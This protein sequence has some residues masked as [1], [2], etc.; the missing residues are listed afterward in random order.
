VRV[1]VSPMADSAAGAPPSGWTLRDV[2]RVVKKEVTSMRWEQGMLVF[3][4]IYFLLVFTTFAIEDRQIARMICG[5]DQWITPDCKDGILTTLDTMFVSLDMVFLC[6]FALEIGIKFFGIGVL[7]YLR[8]QTCTDGVINTFDFIVILI[9]I[10]MNVFVLTTDIFDDAGSASLLPLLKFVRLLRAVMLMTRLQRSRQRLLRMRMVGLAAPVEKVFEIITDLRE[11]VAHA[12]DDKALAWT[13]DLI[14]KEELY[15]VSFTDSKSSSGMHLT[16]EMTDW[17]RSNL[18]ASLPGGL[19]TKPNAATDGKRGSVMGK[20]TPNDPNKART[21]TTSMANAVVPA[22]I[23]K[24]IAEPNVGAILDKLDQWDFDVFAL[25][26]ATNGNPLAVGGM[27]LMTK[28]GVLDRVPIPKDTLATYLQEIEKGY[29]RANPFH[30]ATHAS[31]VMFTTHYF[32][33]AP[34]LRDMTG[35]LDKFAAVLA[36]AVHDYAHPGLSNPFLIV[37]REDKA[38]MYNDQSVLE[39]FHVAGSFRVMLTT[40]GCDITEGMTRE[41]FRQFRETMV[42]MIL[43]TDLKTHFEHLGRLKTRVAT[44]AYS[45]VER[46]DVLLLLGQ[47]LHAADISN[48]TKGRPL[49]MRWTERVMKEFWQQGEKEK[50]LGLPISAFMDRSN[51]QVPQCQLGFVNVLVKPL[52][53]EWH[54]LLGET[55]Q[56]AIN[57][58]E[59][60]LKIWET[61]G[62]APCENWHKEDFVR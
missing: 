27:H 5:G 35:S 31:D 53:V 3:V 22:W 9:S 29:V 2:R 56:P 58:L 62:S 34:L 61:E 37:T 51:P 28:M 59:N 41:Q 60:S 17:L 12:E 18:Q 14:A 43:A 11:K 25:D 44:D 16:A 45:S 21:S 46:K 36:A 52:F 39:M 47:A 24:A 40:P 13:M 4:L 23:T 15:K 7:A 20:D 32:M 54:K 57:E 50:S 8:G 33:Q 55:A 48:P 49:M 38:V 26:E 19:L 42:S 6:V 1:Q 30:N 10:M